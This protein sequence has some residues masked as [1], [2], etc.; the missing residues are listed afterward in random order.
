[1]IWLVLLIIMYHRLYIDK[2]MII[3]DKF[4]ILKNGSMYNMIG[5]EQLKNIPVYSA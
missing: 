4:S 1:M 5:Y 3:L 2:V